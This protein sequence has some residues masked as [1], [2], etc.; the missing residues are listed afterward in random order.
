MGFDSGSM[1]AG[2][3]VC[4]DYDGNNY[5]GKGP[6]NIKGV[7]CNGSE[8]ELQECGGETNPTTC[9]HN[10][11]VMVSCKGSGDASGGSGTAAGGISMPKINKIKIPS[12]IRAT[13]DMQA[14]QVDEFNR[15]ADGGFL[16]VDC[17]TGCRAA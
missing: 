6:V 12:P 17:P 7:N 1:I 10:E 11:D 2:E 13:C 4:L 3:N 14:R 5:C 16:L 9:S 15:L 8:A